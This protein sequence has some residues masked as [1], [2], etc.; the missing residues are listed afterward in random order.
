M[1]NRLL[2]SMLILVVFASGCIQTQPVKVDANN[3]IKIETFAA[4]PVD[5]YDK[6]TVSFTADIE[7]VG[8]NT[9]YNVETELT[10]MD[11][12]GPGYKKFSTVSKMSPPKPDESIPGDIKTYMWEIDAP[13]LSEGDFVSFPVKARVTYDYETGNTI[14]IKAISYDRYSIMQKKGETVE[15]PVS[16]RDDF[17]GPIKIKLAKGATPLIIDPSEAEGKIERVYKLE[18]QNV[19]D[20]WPITD[21]VVGRVTG[22]IEL[23]GPGITLKECTG[24]TGSMSNF[25]VIL[26]SN[27]IAPIACTV[28]IDP[29]RWQTK[30]EDVFR[31]K[32]KFSFRYYV[33]KEVSVT[34][35]GTEKI[36]RISAPA[37]TDRKQPITYIVSPSEGSLWNTDF[38][39][40]VSDYDMDSGL[41]TCEYMV[42]SRGIETTQWATR[43]CSS[44]ITLT[45]GCNQNCRDPGSNTVLLYV[46]S[47]DR[48][49]NVA[50]DSRS[51]SIDRN[52][53]QCPT[54]CGTTCP[55]GCGTTCPTGCGSS[56]P[57]GCGTTCPSG[58]GTNCPTGC[59]SCNY[60]TGC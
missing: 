25:Y 23:F 37:P 35:R 6:S 58:C 16:M 4:D 53:N 28:E 52:C 17:S 21:N 2:F 13:D 27:G 14:A 12:W 47:R 46:R 20:G 39:V 33:E 18:V 24:I 22:S 5:V 1:N 44:S 42:V 19:G 38:S 34:V 41:A 60:W 36:K 56:C 50:S 51:F 31:F 32:A 15:N 43:P 10:G 40:S 29:I 48:A 26:R 7:N 49:G 3:G 8:G 30:T 59:G 45:V 57:S 9:A 54:G 11:V 55:T